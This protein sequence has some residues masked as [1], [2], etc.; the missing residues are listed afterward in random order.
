M[1]WRSNGD[2]MKLLENVAFTDRP[3]YRKCRNA[4]AA[5][6]SRDV[7]QWSQEEITVDPSSPFQGLWKP[8]LVPFLLKPMRDFAE[9]MATDINFMKSAQ[10]AVTQAYMNC[11]LW[12]VKNQPAPFMWV[13][14]TGKVMEK[15]VKGRLEPTMEKCKPIA[16]L[17]PKGKGQ[18]GVYEIYFAR[19]LYCIVTAGAIGELQ[20][21]PF[22]NVIMDEVRDWPKGSYDLVLKRTRAFSRIGYRRITISCPEDHGDI[23]HRGFLAGDQQHWN[24]KCRKC[25]HVQKLKFSW[26]KRGA[27]GLNWRD[28]EY[29]KPNGQWHFPR[30]MESVY[31]ECQNSNCKH[32]L[33]DTDEDRQKIY[34]YGDWIP[35]NP[36]APETSV[37]YQINALLPKWVPWGDIVQEFIKAMLALKYG[38]GQPFKDFVNQTLGE[39][40]KPNQQATLNIETVRKGGYNLLSYVPGYDVMFLT[41][42]KQKDHYHIVARQWSMMRTRLFQEA[43]LETPEEVRK[44]QLDHGI[45]DNHVAM[46]VGFEQTESLRECARFGWA[47]FKGTDKYEFAHYLAQGQPPVYRIYSPLRWMDAYIGTAKQAVDSGQGLVARG[48][49]ED[50]TELRLVPYFLFS[51]FQAKNRLESLRRDPNPEVW[52]VAV[53]VSPEYE[54]QIDGEVKLPYVNKRTGAVTEEWVPV[55]GRQNHKFDCEIG[56]IILASMA[57]FIGS[58]LAEK[59]IKQANREMGLEPLVPNP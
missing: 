54:E 8:G 9:G 33:R 27:A 38:D 43:I 35:E 55:P 22:R 30:L 34:D 19:M 50:G 4:I 2:K 11:S 5:P 24:F 26:G 44:F 28:D 37:S 40:L 16:D 51:N 1:R 3:G 59:E 41:I 52:S 36:N 53:N 14:S 39:P 48:E 31:F 25:G 20:S 13:T 45:E 46:D 57:G 32:W 6:E 47:A 49:D 15:F 17:I 29:T 21:F 12:T 42:D 58:E 10:A 7:V 23:V 18:A 56:Q